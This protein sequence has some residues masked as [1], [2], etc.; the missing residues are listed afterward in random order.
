MPHLST[1]LLLTFGCLATV[2]NPVAAA[3]RV[4][5]EQAIRAVIQ[6]HATA[7]NHRD[8]VAAAAVYA[9]EAVIRTSSGRLLTGRTAIEQ[10]HR[11]WLAE[12]T[13][14]GGSIHLHP[15]ESIKVQFLGVDLAVV[16][17]DG[18]FA[19]R[20]SSNGTQPAAECA[21][22]FIV[23]VKRAGHWQ[24]AEQRALAPARS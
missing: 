18:C 24:V 21:P 19:A 12:D 11:E 14:G 16:D 5:D 17:L 4:A 3:Q 7:W 10:A 15:P 6:A 23:V 2:H 8:A 22:L 20:T 13:V 1:R 9:P